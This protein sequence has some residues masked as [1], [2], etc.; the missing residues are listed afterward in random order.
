MR[1]SKELDR[2]IWE[3]IDQALLILGKDARRLIYEH[4][5]R[6]SGVARL[7]VSRK[8]D[9]LNEAFL[10]L[11]GQFAK[12]VIEETIAERLYNSLGLE[13]KRREGWTLIEYVKEAKRMI[14]LVS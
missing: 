1:S 5:E 10:S 3:E 4:M 8:L 12:K 2:K 9:A 11:M 6:T 7:D 14:R 13:F